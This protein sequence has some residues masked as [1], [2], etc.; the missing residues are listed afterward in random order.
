LAR[1]LFWAAFSVKGN[2]MGSFVMIGGV[3]LSLAVAFNGYK[4]RNIL[5]FLKLT[6][7]SGAAVLA[8][9]IILYKQASPDELTLRGLTKFLVFDQYLALVVVIVLAVVIHLKYPLVSSFLGTFLLYS[10]LAYL[11]VLTFNQRGSL[12]I[13]F[14]LLG[15]TGALLLRYYLKERFTL[16]VSAIGGSVCAS[17]LFTRFYYLPLWLFILLALLF[18]SA[19]IYI[20]YK[21]W[22]KGASR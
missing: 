10:L 1:Q 7:S 8:Y 18:L 22:Q 5:D 15:G 21:S 14:T 20:Q 16:Y 3:L 17:L 2:A 13:V 19:A 12:A 11:L 9:F 4:L 6:V